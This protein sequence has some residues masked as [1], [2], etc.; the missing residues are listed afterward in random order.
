M[1]SIGLCVSTKQILEAF[2]VT[3][4]LRVGPSARYVKVKKNSSRVVM[5]LVETILGILLPS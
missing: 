1:D 2:N 3:D 4:T 5:F